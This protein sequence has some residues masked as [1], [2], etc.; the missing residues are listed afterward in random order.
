MTSYFSSIHFADAF[1]ATADAIPEATAL[2]YG[3][4]RQSWR[5]FDDRAARLATYLHR[6]GVQPGTKV[7]LYLHNCNEYLESQFAAFKQRAVPVNVNFR[8]TTE[9]LEYLLDNADVEVLIYQRRYRENVRTLQ[10]RL[11]KLTTVIEVGA[12]DPA[13]EDGPPGDDYEAV[14]AM[15]DPAPRIPRDARDIY[16]L[17]TGGTTGMPKGVMYEIG[18]LTHAFTA[19]YDRLEIP[20]PQSAEGL[21][22]VVQSIHAKGA[23]PV[24]LPACPL[25]HGTGMWIGALIP[26]MIG[27]A[28]VTMP[29][30]GLD[31]AALLQQVGQHGVTSLVI[32]GDAFARPMLAELDQA[33][34]A[35]TPYALPTLQSMTSSGAMWSREVKAGLLRHK[36]MVLRDAFGSTEGGMGSSETT[37]DG[38]VDT[39][40]FTLNDGVCVFDDDDLPV[41]PGSPEPGMVGLS[42]MCPTGY[43]KDPVKSAATFRTIDGVRYSFPGDLATVAEDG[44]IHLLGR[45]SACINTAGE[46]VFA[47]EVEEAI[48]RVPGI[49]DCLVFGMPDERLG[50]RV[51]AVAES[52]AGPLDAQQVLTEVRTHL[53]GYKLPKA[54]YFADKVQRSP[55]GKA[56]YPWARTMVQT[57]EDNLS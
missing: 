33:A 4:T 19:T 14:I 30:T 55:S 18:T 20:R 3:D 12:H 39:A 47:E 50:Q 13:P 53:A 51:V 5:T 2:I 56:D 46:K 34:K 1:E 25:M 26:H 40:R 7:G 48:K 31:P 29:A 8:Y 24:A 49:A 23:T 16:M 57:K 37:R 43:Y 10:A 15:H 54:L 38:A 41:V 45:G 22:K 28:V 11:A 42:G 21:G 6:V 9:E 35:G 17:Y 32:V 44:T 27:G 36:E 52:C